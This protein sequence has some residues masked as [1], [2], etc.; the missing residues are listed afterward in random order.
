MLP[1]RN[2]CRSART[3]GVGA[4]PPGHGQRSSQIKTNVHRRTAGDDGSQRG[5]AHA[6]RAT[7][8][9]VFAA[10][11]HAAHRAAYSPLGAG[12]AATSPRGARRDIRA[13]AGGG[14]SPRSDGERRAG[15]R[16]HKIYVERFGRLEKTRASFRDDQQLMQ[17]IQRVVVRGPPDRREAARCSTPAWPTVPA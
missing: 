12:T 9:R 16:R 2:D 5:T 13:G 8:G 1:N 6:R 7:S 11:R 3:Q 14:V 10:D 4:A 17:V 15:E